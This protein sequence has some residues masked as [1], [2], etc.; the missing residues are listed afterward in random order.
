MYAVKS[1]N[2]TST[3][4][5]YK[6]F[7][8]IPTFW[9]NPDTCVCSCPNEIN[10]KYTGP[11]GKLLPMKPYWGD[12]SARLFTPTEAGWFVKVHKD[13]CHQYDN[14]WCMLN[15]ARTHLK[16]WWTSSR[17]SR[18]VWKHR[19]SC[20]SSITRELL[21]GSWVRVRLWEE[22]DRILLQKA[23]SQ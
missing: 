22:E 2:Y 12:D 23:I 15:H 18:L 8:Y 14:H 9:C 5:W 17:V 4:S 11:P 13:T 3:M 21:L 19:K 7:P 6:S 10:K 20:A 16:I 1:R